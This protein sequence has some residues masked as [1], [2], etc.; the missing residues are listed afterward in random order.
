MSP[1]QAG[2][3]AGNH[4]PELVIPEDSSRP[5]LDAVLALGGGL[6]LIR[7]G[8]RRRGLLGAL[9]ILLGV[10]ALYRWL[11]AAPDQ[12]RQPTTSGRKALVQPETLLKTPFQS[13]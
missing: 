6:L 11:Y 8:V 5:A 7:Q 1:E 10:A 13:E 3:Q 12:A 4:R 2:E 9:D